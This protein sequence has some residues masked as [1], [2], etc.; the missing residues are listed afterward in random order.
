MP[1]P[2]TQGTPLRLSKSKRRIFTF[3]TLASPV[4]VLVILEVSLRL[5]HYGPDLSLFT[6][7]VVNGR[8][9]HIMNPEVRSRYFAN[10]EFNP[11]TSVDD[12]LVPK[13][14]GTY[15]IFCLGGSTTVG[16]PYW[17]N[18]S[19]STFLR[20]RLQRIFPEKG[21]EVINLGMTATNSFTVVDMA[22]DVVEYEPDLIIV[23]DGHNEFYGALGIS[24]N[25]SP[26]NSRWL[27]QSYL[28]LLHFRTFLLLRDAYAR[29]AG[30]FRP[31]ATVPSRGTMMEK[32]SYGNY[33]AYGS[34][35]YRSALSMFEGNLD[36][37]KSLCTKHRVPL[38]VSTQVSNL[39]DQAP[40]V[41][42]NSAGKTP[43][44]AS[45]LNALINLGLARIRSGKIDSALA[46]FRAAVLVDSLRGDSHYLA[47]RCLD[48]LGDRHSARMEYVL[49]RDYD[50]LRFRTSTD[51][52]D[53]IRRM[54]DDR[55]V[56]VLDM[57]RVFQNHAPDSLIGNTLIMEHLHPNSSGYFVMGE[58][59]AGEM[60]R[61]QMLAS[62][63]E[64]RARDTIGDGE[65]WRERSVSTL[66]EMIAWRRTEILTSGW[67]FT[68]KKVPVVRPVLA[69]DTL[70]QFAEEVT[71]GMWDW[72]RA[73][74]E[75]AAYYERRTEWDS[76][77]MEERVMISQMPL[78]VEPYL[79]LAHAY[80]IRERYQAM[81]SILLRSQTVQPTILACRALGD[82]ALQTGKPL[83][84]IEQYE[85]M[86][87]FKQSA[88][89]RLENGY[90]LALAY[91]RANMRDRADDQLHKLLELDPKYRP[92]AD[93]LAH[94]KGP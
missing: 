29:A 71:R 25:E 33:I 3:V 45:K 80:L 61:H 54:E 6:T 16:Y 31:R 82:Y 26:G 94:L 19:F 12:F 68:T 18:G 90:L 84:A 88:G 63:E 27:T 2:R 79:A 1:S 57:E 28:R 48:S 9:Y 70:G 67:P 78:D 64:W 66:D 58:A 69:T 86:S 13:P 50:Q 7:E 56:F 42:G 4:A 44:E 83:Q 11:S 37:L 91:L 32:M 74:R 53:A 17:Y 35:T 38:I 46:S 40:L 52:N 20:D 55:D 89:E 5:F 76:V 41:P 77:A 81:V 87:A 49:A 15:R 92:A 24:S 36:E 47:A 75:A 22:R 30:L 85:Q 39:R 21:I 60:R 73:H 34:P 14:P 8:R 62:A 65:I 51:F 72:Y 10:M 43:E 93:L 59:F 23:Y